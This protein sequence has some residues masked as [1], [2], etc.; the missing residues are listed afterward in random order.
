MGSTNY[1]GR[2]NASSQDVESRFSQALH[3]DCKARPS[4]KYAGA[5][6]AWRYPALM[7]CFHPLRAYRAPRGGIT[8]NRNSALIEGLKLEVPC[9]HCRGCRVDKAREWAMRC[10]HEAKCWPHNSFVTLTYNPEKLPADGS[11]SKRV[12]QTF[13]KR[14]RKAYGEKTIRFF[15]AAEYTPINRLPHYHILLFNQFFEDQR[16]FKN[17]KQNQPLYTSQILERLWPFG[18]STIGNV[19]YQT[20]RYAAQYSLKKITGDRSPEHYTWPHPIHGYLIRAEPEF[21]LMSR[22]PGIGHTWFER[23][24]SDCYPSD[25]LIVDGK[26]HP[27]PKYYDLKLKKENERQLTRLKRARKKSSRA[28]AENN[29]PA[30]LRVREVLLEEKLKRS[31]RNGEIS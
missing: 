18:F 10:A 31:S 16:L 11:V 26:K 9:G 25:F 6:Y 4:E 29:T 22:R 13:M 3:E 30:R 14:L 2:Q 8:F 24:K 19:N 23:Y 17:N 12:M 7:T 28:N 27:V 20:A 5:A 21:A 1:G 15:G